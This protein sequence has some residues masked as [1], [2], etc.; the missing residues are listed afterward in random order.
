MNADYNIKQGDTLPTLRA[1]L[2][3]GKFVSDLALASVKVTVKS[4]KTNIVKIN[5]ACDIIDSSA[6]LV[7]YAWVVADTDTPGFYS[8]EFEATRPTGKI[9]YPNNGYAILEI[10]PELA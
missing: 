9:T 4:L 8:L 7:E 6:G 5:A 2:K 3:E 1:I 10:L